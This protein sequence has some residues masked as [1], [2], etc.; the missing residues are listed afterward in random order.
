M[1]AASA[2]AAAPFAPIAK[3][4]SAAASA[5]ASL[6]PSPI[7]MTGPFLRSDRTTS[8]FWSG[9]RSDRTA[10]ID[11]P[12]TTFSATSRRSPVART[13]RSIPSLPQTAQQRLRTR[14]QFVGEDQDPGHL[15]INSDRHCNRSGGLFPPREDAPSPVTLRLTKRRPPTMTARPST[16]PSMPSPGVS[17]TSLG[18][19]R[20]RLR[21][22]ASSTIVSAMTCFEAWSSDAASRRSSLG[23]RSEAMVVETILARPCVSVPVLSSTSERTCARVSSAFPPLISMPCLAARERP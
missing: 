2:E 22:C 19:V 9:V 8:V 7:I 16:R 3:P 12:A 17:A 18:T 4:R 15:S 20:S 13:I 10:S 21:V 23:D 5:G 14:P 6:T 11:R 1:S